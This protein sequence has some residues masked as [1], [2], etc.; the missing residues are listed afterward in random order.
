VRT[1]TVSTQGLPDTPSNRHLG[2]AWCRLLV[3]AH[4]KPLC[5][6]HA[7]APIV[8][9]TNRQAASQ[10]L[11][12]C[13]QRGEDMRP[14]VLRQ[15]KVDAT[16]VEGGF[17]EL[18]PTPFTGPTELVP[19]VN[20]PLGRHDLTVVNIESALEQITCVPVLRTLRRQLEADQVQYQETALLSEILESLSPPAD[21]YA[22]L[23]VPH[24]DRGMRLAEPH[25]AGRARDAGAPLERVA[26]SLCWLTLLM[27]LFY[28][29]VPL[30][31]LG[32]WFGVHKTTMLP[33][34]AAVLPSQSQWACRWI[35]T[36]LHL[37][38]HV[39][40]LIITEGLPAYA[41]LVPGAKHVL[42]RFHH[43]QGV[44]HWLKQHFA[45]VA[46]I[47]ARKPVMKQVFRTCDKRT[48]RRRLAQLKEHASALGIIP[49]ITAVEAK[50]PKLM[51]RVGSVR[52]PSTTHAIE[53]FFRAF[54]RLDTTR[55][56]FH[57][58]LS[59]KRALLLFAVVYL[60]TQQASTGR[61]PIEV[62]VPEARRMPL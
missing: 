13:R 11:E 10:H 22:S 12:A 18:L 49:W 34:L 4:G 40:Q 3:N 14:F 28:W 19:R 45:T 5:T 51:C 37:L 54:Q 33:V 48:V 38:K 52:I 20:A 44:T 56:G 42:C 39:P 27:T 17:T 7:F 25:G 35:G 24:V 30:S 53:R 61:A 46:E 43:Q 8:G 41:Y 57:S 2:V 59:A 50:R 55:G 62:M 15:R 58:I 26:D 31:V 32:R 23:G 21:P 36:Q 1:P 29:N 60:F 16:V 6:W 9:S 47:N